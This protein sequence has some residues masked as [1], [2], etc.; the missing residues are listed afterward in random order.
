MKYCKFDEGHLKSGIR[1]LSE[2]GNIMNLTSNVNF[3]K[4]FK[5]INEKHFAEGGPNLVPSKRSNLTT[6]N[7]NLSVKLP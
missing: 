5:S 6:A 4:K 2:K 1:E 7:R 3:V